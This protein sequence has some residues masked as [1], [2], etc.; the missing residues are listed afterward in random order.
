MTLFLTRELGA[1]LSVAGSYFLTYL[2]APLAGFMIGALSDRRK[3]RLVIF[4]ICVALAGAGWLA[5]GLSNQ[6]WMPFVIGAVVLSLT[7]AIMAQLLAAVR[8]QLSRRPTAAENRILAM[9]RMGF[10]GGWVVGPC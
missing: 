3:D 2:V 6:L 7:G 1:S 4:R 10:S 9:V 8:D 5:I